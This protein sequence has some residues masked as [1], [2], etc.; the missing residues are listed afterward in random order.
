MASSPICL[1]QPTSGFS[2]KTTGRCASENWCGFKGGGWSQQIRIRLIFYL[3]T[4]IYRIFYRIFSLRNLRILKTFA[5]Y[6][7]HTHMS[8]VVRTR[9]YTSTY[10]PT[11]T[12]TAKTEPPGRT[13]VLRSHRVERK[14]HTHVLPPHTRRHPQTGCDECDQREEELSVYS[15]DFWIYL[16]FFICK[17]T[18]KPAHLITIDFDELCRRVYVLS[19]VVHRKAFLRQFL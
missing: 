17:A 16:S 18:L 8:P 14:Y 4:A 2:Y 5:Q 1:E 11:H 7:T 3:Y 12:V 15:S 9:T 19:V 6:C 10:A 13:F